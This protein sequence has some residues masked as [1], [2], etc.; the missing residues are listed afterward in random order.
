MGFVEEVYAISKQF[1]ESEKFALTV[2]IRK[3]AI[4][5]P[6]N[7][8]E[9]HG[10]KTTNNYV[11]FLAIALG[12]LYELETQLHIAHRLNYINSFKLKSCLAVCE[13]LGKM[14]NKLIS[15]LKAKRIP[16]TPNP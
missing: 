7:I 9:G 2:H 14:L 13:E 16:L 12:S 4:S 1:P 8:A 10:R 11:H 3:T 6:S 15:T 5:I